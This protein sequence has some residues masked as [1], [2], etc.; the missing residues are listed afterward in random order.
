VLPA[1]LLNRTVHVFL[2]LDPGLAM[3]FSMNEGDTSGYVELVDTAVLNAENK[4]Q[5]GPPKF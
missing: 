3:R 1:E 2:E 4:A 5:F